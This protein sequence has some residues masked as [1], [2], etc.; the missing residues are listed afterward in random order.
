MRIIINLKLLF[1]LNFLILHNIDKY[2]KKRNF[3]ISITNNDAIC[4]Y[5]LY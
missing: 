1:F 4:Y 3:Q 2:I 5:T